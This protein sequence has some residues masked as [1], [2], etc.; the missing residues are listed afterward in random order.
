MELSKFCESWDISQS[1]NQDKHVREAHAAEMWPT[2]PRLQHTDAHGE[3]L[4]EHITS[5]QL[6]RSNPDEDYFHE[7]TFLSASLLC[8]LRIQYSSVYGEKKSSTWSWLLSLSPFLHLLFI[9]FHLQLENYAFSLLM[10]LVLT[11]TSL[12]SKRIVYDPSSTHE[13]QWSI[14]LHC[15]M[16][17]GNGSSCSPT[18]T[19]FPSTSI[20]WV[21]S[22]FGVAAIF[23]IQRLYSYKH[24]NIPVYTVVGL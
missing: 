17:I 7:A 6:K 11:L 21:E 19:T 16:H 23:Q 18:V 4:T 14:F 3:S 1:C 15:H 2:R 13:K 24:Q 9:C 10:L 22:I 5:T 12:L 8:G 20:F